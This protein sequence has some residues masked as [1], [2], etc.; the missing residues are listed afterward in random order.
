MG[1]SEDILQIDLIL[2]IVAKLLILRLHFLQSSS[3]DLHHQHFKVFLF[4]Y[5]VMVNYYTE[6]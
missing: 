2:C 1:E 3:R 5:E 4:F 6:A